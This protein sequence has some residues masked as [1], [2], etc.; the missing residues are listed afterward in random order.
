[1]LMELGQSTCDMTKAPNGFWEV[2]TKPLVP[3]FHYYAISVDGFAS[4]DPGSSIFFAA[5]KEQGATPK[6]QPAEVQSLLQ[7]VP[8]VG[9]S[10]S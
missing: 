9:A 6:I 8:L 4:N 5:R 3:G 7:K 10:K 1:M 2:T